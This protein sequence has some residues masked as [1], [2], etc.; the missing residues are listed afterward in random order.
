ML[1]TSQIVLSLPY[2]SFFGTDLMPVM[3]FMSL[4]LRLTTNR[5]KEIMTIVTTTTK[6]VC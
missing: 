2:V 3:L 4:F 6:D 5:H 1:G